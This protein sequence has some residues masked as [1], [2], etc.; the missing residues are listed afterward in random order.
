MTPNSG[1]GAI[2]GVPSHTPSAPPRPSR[3][4][5]AA[6]AAAA[7]SDKK[8]LETAILEVERRLYELET[9]L[10]LEPCNIVTGFEGVPKEAVS[11]PKLT[12]VELDQRIFS[13]SSL[14]SAA[15]SA[16]RR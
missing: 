15:S 12:A 14:T 13:L 10:L 11:A 3:A 5:A 2:G 16:K 4:A 7:I 8:K 1:P 9:K 6:A